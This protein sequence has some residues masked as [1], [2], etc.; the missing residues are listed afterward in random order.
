MQPIRRAP[1]RPPARLHFVRRMP[2]NTAPHSP[3]KSDG[4]ERSLDQPLNS[5]ELFVQYAPFVGRF[6]VRMGV[7]RA[8][9]DDLLQEVFLV[10]HRIG[11]YRP[12][13]AKPTTYLASIAV[14]LVKTERRKRQVRSFVEANDD[15]VQAAAAEGDP[16]QDATERQGL[17]ELQ[18]VLDTLDD[19]KRAVF[20]LYELEELT[21]AE[22]AAAVGCP[23]QTAYSR[24]HAARKLV[25][26]GVAKARTGA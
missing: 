11:G 26:A 12:G 6:L 8:D 14:K 23:L 7:A 13:P 2:R 1:N 22:V 18:R 20:V 4:A 10:A 25:E 17:I 16:E 19:D 5:K 21:V 9:V 15:H 24:L 3:A